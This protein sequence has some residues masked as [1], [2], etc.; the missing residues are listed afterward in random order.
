MQLKQSRETEAVR[1]INRGDYLINNPPRSELTENIVDIGNLPLVSFCIPTKNNED[2][3]EK[4]LQSIVNQNYP[5]IEIVIID[6]TSSDNTVRVAK[7][8]TDKIYNESGPLGSARQKSIEY[9][10]GQIVALFDSDIIIPHDDWLLNAIKFFNYCEPVSTVW[11]FCVAPPDSTR[12]ARL[13]Q[14]NFYKIVMEDRIKKKRG[15]F[16]GGNALFQRQCFSEIGGINEHIHW[17]EDFDWALKLRDKDYKVVLIDDPLYHDT[18]RTV[19]QFWKKQFA[20]AETFTQSGF[21][22]MALSKK[23][24][25]YEHF[26]L[27]IKGMITGLIVE[28]DSAW[29][30]Y[31]VLLSIRSLAYASTYIRNFLRRSEGDPYVS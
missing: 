27:G 18:M 4:C 12:F 20:G 15:L 16:G 7:R 3:L 30:L 29:L 28:R 25:I 5:T 8:Y 11:P 1:E 21:G 14:T 23:D 2:T 31:P 19:R 6:G 24:V 10:K 22:I 26:I 9:S 13:Y 17:G